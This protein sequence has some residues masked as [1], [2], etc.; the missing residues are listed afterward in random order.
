MDTCRD[1]DR[2][3]LCV[4]V[5]IMCLNSSINYIDVALAFACIAMY[6][7]PSLVLVGTSW[8]A[9]AYSIPLL[10]H[11]HAILTFTTLLIGIGR[12]EGGHADC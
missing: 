9:P 8:I 6:M 11:L 3:R 12:Q 7:W 5:F 4:G 10:L 1:R 2:D